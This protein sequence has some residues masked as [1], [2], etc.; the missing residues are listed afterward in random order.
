MRG[1]DPLEV[2]RANPIAFAL[3]AIIAL[4]ARWSEG[5]YNADGLERGEAML[6]DHDACGMTRQQYRTALKHLVK[7]GFVATRPTPAGTI[8]WLTDTRLFDPLN[9]GGIQQTNHQPTIAQPPVNQPTTT[10]EERN[11]GRRE[12]IK[13]D[14]IKDSLAS[15]KMNQETQRTV[16]LLDMCRE[17]L[18]VE[19]VQRCH[20]RWLKRAETDPDKLASVLAEVK[21]MTARHSIKTTPARVAEDL[22]KRWKKAKEREPLKPSPLSTKGKNPQQQVGG[23]E[24]VTAEMS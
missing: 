15:L 23:A 12:E 5:S 21:E 17:V 11:N 22:W 10:N 16:E 3:A 6:G 9:L 24:H 19:E 8:A 4:R 7:C 20:N 13:S 2:I 14:S 18:G 1:N